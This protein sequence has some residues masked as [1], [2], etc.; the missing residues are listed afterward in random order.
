[1]SLN[2][3]AFGIGGLV[4]GGALGALAMQVRLGSRLAAERAA[5]HV[6]EAR[7]SDETEL[8]ARLDAAGARSHA[9]LLD[10]AQRE[11]EPLR[12]ALAA[13]HDAVGTLHRTH[14]AF[15]SVLRS[16]VERLTTMHGALRTETGRL[17]AALRHPRARGNWGEMTLRIVVERAGMLKHCDFAEQR[18]VGA[19][20]DS[21]AQRPDLVVQLPGRGA[22]AVDAKVPLAK[23]IDIVDAPEE[24]AAARRE[25]LR[26]HAAAIDAHARALAKKS[27]WSALDRAPELVVLFLNVEAA[28][29]GALEVDPELFDRA[30][31]RNVVIATPATLLGL[32]KAIAVGWRDD[33]IARNA[34]AIAACGSTV[35]ERLGVFARHLDGVGSALAAAGRKYQDA[36]GSFDRRVAPAVRQLH[37]LSA[38]S[39]EPPAI[40]VPE[41]FEPRA[42]TAFAETTGAEDSKFPGS[43]TGVST[44][45]GVSGG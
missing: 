6:A 42:V 27:Y 24:S 16:E 25:R 10:A 28:L 18:G 22:V 26:A 43:R 32:L 2:D 36:V 14:D 13:Q 45:E 12:T 30:M 23:W 34:E 3:L 33:A 31:K 5:R 7:L 4:T 38:A 29:V 1:M 17:A 15:A 19:A 44:P 35:L 8:A 21:A 40:A 41:P 39:G 9:A 37:E 20:D 11:F